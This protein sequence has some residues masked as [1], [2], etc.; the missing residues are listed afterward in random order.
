M[1]RQTAVECIARKKYVRYHDTL[2]QPT[3]YI[4][5]LQNGKWFH[6]LELQDLNTSSVTIAAM[7]QVN[8]D[9]EERLKM[10]EEDKR[11]LQDKILSA[12]QYESEIKKIA[13]KYSI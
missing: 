10:Y 4:M 8:L 1:D 11:K 5:R 6:S 3:A 9:Y 7:Y 12:D 13:D 2:Y